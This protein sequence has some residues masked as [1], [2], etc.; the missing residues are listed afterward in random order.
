MLRPTVSAIVNAISVSSSVA[1]PLS[2]TI[3][4]TGRSSVSVSPKSPVATLPR[5]SKYWTMIG[6]SSPAASRRR[7]SSY[8][9]S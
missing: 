6:R 3:D 8:A 7:S 1:L 2:T 5:Y 4:V 9:G